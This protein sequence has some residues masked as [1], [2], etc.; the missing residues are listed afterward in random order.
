MLQELVST[1]GS[2]RRLSSFKTNN[3]SRTEL[4][5]VAR[6]GDRVIPVEVKSGK[7]VN[8]KSI[9]QLLEYMRYSNLKRG[10]VIYTGKPMS[11]E[12]EGLEIFFIPPYYLPTM[13][14]G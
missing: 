2:I 4:D 3:K 12:T 8:T 11:R 14:L 6:V 7:R 9:N 13:L 1:C 5:F 10:Y